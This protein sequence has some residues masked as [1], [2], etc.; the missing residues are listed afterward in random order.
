MK[1]YPPIHPLVLDTAAICFQGDVR[2]A[3]DDTRHVIEGY[4]REKR[5]TILYKLDKYGN[6][7]DTGSP[8]FILKNWLYAQCLYWGVIDGRKRITTYLKDELKTL[9]ETLPAIEPVSHCL[10]FG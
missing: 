6:L 10:P 4:E 8:N 1:T 5:A 3:V 2:F 9:L 7:L